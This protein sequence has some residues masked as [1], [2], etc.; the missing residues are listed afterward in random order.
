VNETKTDIEL[1]S[2]VLDELK[3]DPTVNAAN[4][5]VS[6]KKGVI[7]L[8]GHVPSY[9]E[10]YAAERVAKRVS[11]VEAVADELDVKLP[12][13]SARSDQDIALACV[14]AMKAHV[15]VPDDRIKITVNDGWLVLEGQ[16]E[17]Q[18]QK[19]AAF[20]AVRYL[21]GVKGVTNRIAIK[22]HISAVALKD[23]I[24]TAFKRTAELDAEAVTVEARGG[25]VTLRGKVRSWAER[26]EA[27]RAAWSAPG[28]TNV[29]NGIEVRY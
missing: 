22:P 2:D 8:S 13:S 18:Y 12:G 5:G 17:W 20:N 1:Q 9:A 6:S 3:W 26:D 24:E 21:T 25:T 28:V 16:V 23:K 11:G 15:S 19:D 14:T 4:I 7:T 27:G 29:D 10:K